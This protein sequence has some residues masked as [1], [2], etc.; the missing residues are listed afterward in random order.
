MLGGGFV[1]NSTLAQR[2]SLDA[3]GEDAGALKGQGER[4]EM[5]SL[6]TAFLHGLIG[7]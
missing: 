7:S 5:M 3:N 6:W 2:A 4:S 1:G